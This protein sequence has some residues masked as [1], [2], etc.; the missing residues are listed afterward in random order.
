MTAKTT[1]QIVGDI[2]YLYKIEDYRWEIIDLIE[3]GMFHTARK[4]LNK[5]IK[6]IDDHPRG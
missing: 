6:E 3:N 2:A 5:C 4:I 1:E